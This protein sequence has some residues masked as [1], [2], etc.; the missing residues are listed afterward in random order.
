MGARGADTRSL[1][2]CSGRQG[3]WASSPPPDS[4]ALAPRPTL[5]PCTHLLSLILCLSKLQAQTLFKLLICPV[6]E[7][8]RTLCGHQDALHL[9][10]RSEVSYLQPHTHRLSL[11]NEKNYNPGKYLLDFTVCGHYHEGLPGVTSQHPHSKAGIFSYS[12]F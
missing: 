8:L 7:D 3:G 2:R 9:P 5:L 1:V 6:E 10:R 12:Y 4:A 11:R